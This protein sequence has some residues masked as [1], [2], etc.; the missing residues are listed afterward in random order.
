M[1]VGVFVVEGHDFP[2]G[3]HQVNKDNLVGIALEVEDHA[4]EIHIRG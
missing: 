1:D 4:T 2:F 3:I